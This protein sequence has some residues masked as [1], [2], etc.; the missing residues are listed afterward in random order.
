MGLSDSVWSRSGVDTIPRRMFYLVI[1]AVLT[2]GFVL[3]ALVSQATAM[4]QP[5]IVMLLLVGLALPIVGIILSVAS[6]NPLV[7]FVGF[8]LVVGGIAAILGPVLAM[9]AIKSPGAIEHA[10][11]FT[12]GVT[13]V[14]GASGFV[15]PDFY[16][17]IGGALFAALCALV[18]VSFV[19]LF[20][21]GLRD[22]HVLD[23]VAAIIFS[24]YIGFDMW[25]ASEMPSTVDNAVDV[26]VSLYLDI[27]NL[28]LNLLS[29]FGDD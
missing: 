3:T 15:F 5:G 18:I 13:V 24:L 12:A 23:Y 26:A 17:S 2:W 7:S 16:R 20:I 10:A 1:G 29:I 6:D 19:S 25:R 4:W 22:N 28:F 8:N 11:A 9:Y 27:I 21:P 14:M